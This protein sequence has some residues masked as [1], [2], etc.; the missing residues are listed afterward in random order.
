MSRRFAPSS[1]IEHRKAERM[2]PVR[3]LGADSEFARASW[4]RR[5]IVS[6]RRFQA[7]CAVTS[8]NP[9]SVGQGALLREHRTEDAKT[10]PA[11]DAKQCLPNAVAL[12]ATT[13]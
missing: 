13:N 6:S 7:M 1:S 2:K 11:R 5:G 10:W 4:D 8:T 9:P 3:A 12:E